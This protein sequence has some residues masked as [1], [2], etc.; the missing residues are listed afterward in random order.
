M[1]L[2]FLGKTFSGYCMKVFLVINEAENV[3]KNSEK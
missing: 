3:G 2:H 1:F